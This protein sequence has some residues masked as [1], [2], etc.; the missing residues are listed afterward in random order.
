MAPRQVALDGDHA[1]VAERR[2]LTAFGPAGERLWQTTISADDPVDAVT[3]GDGLVVVLRASG[4]VALAERSGAVS[5]RPRPASSC[6]TP[7]ATRRP[8]ARATT[9]SCCG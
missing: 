7:I 2:S 3:Q 9:T 5:G 6:P 8:F 4:L 1:F